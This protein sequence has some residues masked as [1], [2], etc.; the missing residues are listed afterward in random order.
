MVKATKIVRQ[1]EWF[2]STIWHK[3]VNKFF[4][5]FTSVMVTM[6][7]LKFM[8]RSSLGFL[9]VRNSNANFTTRNRKIPRQMGA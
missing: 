9:Y 7:A 1:L 6:L 3:R 2:D 4:I 8:A 5:A